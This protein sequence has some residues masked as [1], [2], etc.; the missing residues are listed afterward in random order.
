M[1]IP[2]KFSAAIV[3]ATILVATLQAINFAHADDFVAASETGN[4]REDRHDSPDSP[5][6]VT[7]VIEKMPLMGKA[8]RAATPITGTILYHALGPVMINPNVYSL[9]YGTWT[10][11]CGDTNQ[12]TTSGILNNLISGIGSS[13]WYGINTQYYQNITGK[14]Y[15]TNIVNSSGC[16]AQSATMGT[17]LD[18]GSFS[19]TGSALISSKTLTVSDTAKIYKGERVSGT[20]IRN[21][22]LVTAVGPGKVITISNA[23]TATFTNATITISNPTTEMVVAKSIESGAFGG[24]PDANGLYFLFTSTDISVS[25]FLTQFC[26]YHSYSDFLGTRIKYSFVGDPTSLPNAGCTP[27]SV[28][29]HSNAAG[30]A[31][32]SVTAHELVEAVSDPDINA[33]YDSRGNE[34]ADKCNFVFGATTPEVNASASNVTIGSSRYLI[35]Q[36]WSPVSNGCFSAVPPPPPPVSASVSIPSKQLMVGQAVAAFTPVTASAGTAPYTYSLSP[37]AAGLR[38]NATTGQITA[39]GTLASTSGAVVETVLI[40]DSRA[41]TISKTFSLQVSPALTLTTTHSASSSALSL[42]KNATNVSQQVVTA[43]GS[44]YTSYT[45]AL[46]AGTLPT[47]LSIDAATG[48]LKGNVPNTAQNATSYTVRVTDSAGFTTTR[49]FFLKIV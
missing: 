17:A 26:G 34:N 5:S 27:Q 45:Y 15:V 44:A 9:Y 6:K 43:G 16:S 22:S 19:V 41:S 8:L 31:M 49:A 11:P 7:S 30:D 10:S 14:Q 13:D 29:P 12:T 4:I 32:A 23:T 36:N 18:G 47:G 24:A 39:S 21:G 42:S 28:S 25:G 48:L 38:I 35:Q 40:T 2:K 20:G 37:A 1:L 3:S 33:W 46:S